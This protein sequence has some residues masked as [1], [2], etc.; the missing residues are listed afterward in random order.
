MNT[1][2]I[3]KWNDAH[4]CSL[5]SQTNVYGMSK[6]RTENNTNKLLVSTIHRNFLSIEYQKTGDKLTPLTKDILFTY[7]P[8]DAE[9]VSMDAMT[10]L[11]PNRGLVVG[12][13]F[14]K[15][16]DQ[17]NRP[18]SQML[19]YSGAPLGEENVEESIAGESK[20]E[21][22]TDGCQHIHLE[23]RPFL[24]THTALK[25]QQNTEPEAVFLLSGSD[26]KVH[27]Y[28]EI[29]AEHGFREEPCECYFPEFVNLNNSVLQ[30]VIKTTDCSHRL[31]AIGLQDGE[32]RVTLV[33]TDKKEIIKVWTAEMDSPVTSLSFFSHL[34]CVPCPS[35][36]EAFKISNSCQNSPAADSVESL[37]INLLMSSALGQAAVYR[38]VIGHGL[39]EVLW[40]PDSD[41]YD[42]ALC[43]LAADID[44]DGQ[45][46]ILI[47]TYGQEVLVYKYFPTKEKS[48][49]V[50]SDEMSSWGVDVVADL[51]NTRP[52]SMGDQADDSSKHRHKS[53]EGSA[54]EKTLPQ[55]KVKSEEDLSLLKCK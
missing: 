5:S 52:Y 23:F 54:T 21:V 30:L 19:I 4:F 17:E 39:S 13:T 29:P 49:P 50:E 18:I 10:R 43:S 32:V 11:P 15:P 22:M 25:I 38:D 44:F 2:K 20:L 14:I 47:G 35:F 31:T 24:L 42:V 36:L 12:I 41:R 33:D 37:E 7:I 26:C 3:F 1:T 28:Q 46:E 9:I 48:V 51:R 53:D 27:M 16:E 55:R 45:N 8:G 34:K 40:L 6:I